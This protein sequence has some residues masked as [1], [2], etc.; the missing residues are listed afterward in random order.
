MQEMKILDHRIKNICV[1]QK[2][3][4]A[5]SVNVFEVSKSDLAKGIPP[6]QKD[7]KQ[8]IEEDFK[9]LSS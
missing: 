1:A 3:R 9:K 8:A 4:T 5:N 2:L 6:D 7:V